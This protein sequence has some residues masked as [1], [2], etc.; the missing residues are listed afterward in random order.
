MLQSKANALPTHPEAEHIYVHSH[1]AF[2]LDYYKVETKVKVGKRKR[3]GQVPH[4][5][6][7]NKPIYIKMKRIK[8]K[9]KV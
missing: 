8:N 2:G 7:T 5:L 6:V 3:G 4:S 1:T 9:K